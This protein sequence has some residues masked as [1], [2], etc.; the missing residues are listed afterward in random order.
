MP[1]RPLFDDFDRVAQLICQGGKELGLFVAVVSLGTV[2]V[3]H[4]A[5]I[6]KTGARIGL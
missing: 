3:L 6:A 5:I 4:E 1:F 2:P